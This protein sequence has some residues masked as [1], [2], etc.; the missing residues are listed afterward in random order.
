MS[1]E[2]PLRDLGLK[3]ES[4][5]GGGLHEFGWGYGCEFGFFQRNRCGVEPL[6]FL[7]WASIRP[8]HLIYLLESRLEGLIQPDNIRIH[9]HAGTWHLRIA[10]K[11]LDIRIDHTNLSAEQVSK[12]DAV[13]MLCKKYVFLRRKFIE[14]LESGHKILI[15]RTLDYSMPLDE[16][17]RLSEAARA[18]GDNTVLYVRQADAGEG[19]FRVEQIHEGLMVGTIDRF[20]AQGTRVLPSND[21]GWERICREAVRRKSEP[22][23]RQMALSP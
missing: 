5:G 21:A 1:H 12:S 20:G 2:M 11:N 15:Y 19:P 13:A 14:T 4:L 17:R 8:Q 6:G 22:A 3:F 10:T 18:Y 16:L 23:G 7:R 9:A